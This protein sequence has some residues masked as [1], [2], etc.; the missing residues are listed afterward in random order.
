MAFKIVVGYD[1]SEGAKGALDEAAG[2]ARLLSAELLVTYAFGGPKQYAGAPLTPRHTLRELGER[3]VNE[4]LAR[5][6]DSGVS[7]Q[8]VLVDDNSYRGL[9][10][11]AEQHDAGMIV[12]GTHG[13]V[14]LSGIILGSTPYRLVHSSKRPVLVVPMGATGSGAGS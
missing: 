12:V 11:V 9:I 1:G 3:L 7:A 8:P 13:E 5:I 6:A 4:G 10:S 14:M 2:L